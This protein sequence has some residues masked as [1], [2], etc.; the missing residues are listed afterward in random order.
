MYSSD[1]KLLSVK[2]MRLFLNINFL[3]INLIGSIF[4]R[5]KILFIVLH[6]GTMENKHMY[7]E[8]IAGLRELEL[9]L[10]NDI[11]I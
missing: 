7:E 10:K 2:V 9:F 4:L 3:D 5:E 8:E 1:F 11:V 6:N